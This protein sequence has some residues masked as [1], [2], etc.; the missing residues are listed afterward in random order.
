MKG[1]ERRLAHAQGLRGFGGAKKEATAQTETER[2]AVLTK[3]FLAQV[4][5]ENQEATDA[6]RKQQKELDEAHAKGRARLASAQ[7]SEGSSAASQGRALARGARNGAVRAGTAVD[8]D[9][10]IEVDQA[11]S[12]AEGGEFFEELKAERAHDTLVV[13]A[14]EDSDQELAGIEA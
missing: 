7:L 9:A 6:T 4:M 10:T 3:M 12:D 13:S 14:G 1:V 2:A 11:S 8:D 5:Q